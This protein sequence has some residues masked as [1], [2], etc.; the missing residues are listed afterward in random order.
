[1]VAAWTPTADLEGY[2]GIVHGGIVSTVLDEAMA[3]IVAAKAGRALTV[4]LR[5][6]FRR[7]VASGEAVVI[8][9]WIANRDKR[10]IQSEARLVGSDGSEL[11]HAWGT[12]LGSS[13]KE[14]MP[15]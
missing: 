7:M 6:R 1:M 5:V 15:K 11:A 3:K 10:L 9:G 4:E 8:S 12:F 14:R 2:S 13:G